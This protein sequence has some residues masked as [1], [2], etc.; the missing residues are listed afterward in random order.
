[1]AA[2]R[3]EYHDPFGGKLGFSLASRTPGLIHVSGM[4]GFEPDM[5]V[6]EGVEAQMRLAYSSIQGILDHYG[7]TLADTVE[8]VVFA[9]GDMEAA[10]AAFNLVSREIFGDTPPPCTM[11]GVTALV[12]PR[13]KVEIKVTALDRSA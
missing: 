2:G 13:Y 9:V 1:M 8:Q 3:V 5:S 6:P 7:V 4:T 10:V 11:V 12:D